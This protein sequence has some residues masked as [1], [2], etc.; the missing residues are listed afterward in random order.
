MN[1]ERESLCGDGGD[2]RLQALELLAE[3]GPPVDNEEHVAVGIVDRDRRM[4]GA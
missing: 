2:R 4:R 3:V 1:T